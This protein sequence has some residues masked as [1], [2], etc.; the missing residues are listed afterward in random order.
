[1]LS[2]A[3]RA[4]GR[5][6]HRHVHT[7]HLLLGLLEERCSAT[8]ILKSLGLNRDT[9]KRACERRCDKG[10]NEVEENLRMTP[11]VQEI[12]SLAGEEMRALGHTEIDTRHLL[13]GMIQEDQGI[14]GEVLRTFG[15]SQDAVRASIAG[16]DKEVVES[17]SHTARSVSENEKH[18]VRKPF[19]KLLLRT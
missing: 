15:I 18:P 9:V 7:E 1:M 16:K 14:A 17:Q 10:E 4:A 5:Y 6:R 2:N 8:G 13:L 3:H 19:W 12:F 11:R